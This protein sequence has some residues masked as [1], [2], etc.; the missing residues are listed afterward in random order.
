MRIEFTYSQYNFVE[1]QPEYRISSTNIPHTKKLSH[2][3]LFNVGRFFQQRETLSHW[4][5]LIKDTFPIPLGYPSS[6][7]LFRKKFI[8]YK[9]ANI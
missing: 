9:Y 5:F 8:K 4:Q 7:Q 1:Y 3:V 6:Q 2:E